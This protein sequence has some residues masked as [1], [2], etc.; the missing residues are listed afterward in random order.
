M[1]TNIEE[2]VDRVL[3]DHQAGRGRRPVLPDAQVVERYKNGQPSKYSVGGRV[4]TRRQYHVLVAQL[5]DGG[6]LPPRKTPVRK[7]RAG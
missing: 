5:Q 6:D 4:L 7:P 3:A 1:V 2:A